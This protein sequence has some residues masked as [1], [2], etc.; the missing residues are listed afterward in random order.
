MTL[1]RRGKLTK[2]Q[3]GEIIE[4]CLY[5]HT[6]WAYWRKDRLTAQGW[7][8]VCTCRPAPSP[9]GRLVKQWKLPRRVYAAALKDH[10]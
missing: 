9:R 3:R 5:S 6:G 2:P 7:I 4:R 1:P 10:G 8:I